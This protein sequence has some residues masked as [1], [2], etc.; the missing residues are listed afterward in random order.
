M[1]FKFISLVTVCSLL[2]FASTALAFGEIRYPDRPLNLRAARSARSEWVGSLYPGQKVRVA[3]LN[4]GWVAVFEPGETRESESAAV[5]FSN[6]KYLKKTQTRV[7]PKP[8]GELAYAERNLNIRSEPSRNGE[9]VDMLVADQHVRIDFPE[10]DWTMVFSPDATIRSKLNGI[11]YCSAK[12]LAPATE[13]S[14]A[15]ARLNTA[16]APKTEADKAEPRPAA[17]ASGDWGRVVVIKRKI[18]LREGRTTGSQYIRTLKPGERVR[19]DF[20]KNGWYAVFMPN[21]PIHSE[22]RAMGYALQSLLDKGSEDVGG[23]VA[24]VK[25]AVAPAPVVSQAA[26]PEDEPVEEP[27]EIET[28]APTSVSSRA[29]VQP[30]TVTASSQVEALG[31]ERKTMV[32]D[33]SR[34]TET[35]RPDPTPN[36]TAHGYQYRL[37]EK[38]ETKKLGDTWIT[39][40]IFLATTQLPGSNALEDFS[41]TLWKD[42]KKP[43]KNLAV[44]IYLP[45]QDTEDLAYGVVQFSDTKLLELWV[46]KATLLGTDFL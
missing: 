45:G 18:N 30:E 37:L 31:G 17:T 46:R 1:R 13:K 29:E 2:L 43:G 32:I 8:W 14:L 25:Q 4:D 20:D 24:H 44:L 38:S 27:E 36:K 3:F 26:E 15:K 9:R 22:N 10:D 40:K 33:R 21:E 28:S 7:E 42:H 41:T 35:K 34:F 19:L 11:G 16:Q 23:N 6:V 5:G 12:Y 39:L